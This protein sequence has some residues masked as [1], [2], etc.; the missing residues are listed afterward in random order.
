MNVRPQISKE[1]VGCNITALRKTLNM[2][3]VELAERSQINEETLEK[4]ESGERLL[5]TEEL[6]QLTNT[7]Q[8]PPNYLMACTTYY[9][10]EEDAPS[11]AVTDAII[12]DAKRYITDLF[13]D[14]A[15]GH[16]VAHSL[17]VYC[18]A[19]EIAKSYPEGNK[20]IIALAALL[21]DADDH[22]LFHTE[23]NANARQFLA[24]Y[25]IGKSMTNSIIFAINHVSFSQNP[26][27]GPL[28]IMEEGIVQDADRLDAIGAIG[29]AR[30][31]AYGSKHDRTLES[32]IQHFHDKLLLLKN[33]MNTGIGWEMAKERHAFMEAFL[34]EYQKEMETES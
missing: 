1:R 34:A 10:F 11:T 4:V 6:I 24:R 31:F 9:A 18:N 15:D 21:H 12:E 14:N 7:L 13:K 2:T 28:S 22:K 27:Q 17:R 26:D 25:D 8:V 23:N 33:R 3:R 19:M 20:T 30:V 29:I 5:K 16:D 32:S